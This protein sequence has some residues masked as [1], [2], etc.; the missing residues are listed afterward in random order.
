M[1]VIRLKRFDR[2]KVMAH[3]NSLFLFDDNLE[4]RGRGGQAVIRDLPNAL[5]VPTRRAPRRDESAYFTD[6]DYNKV[7]R[8]IYE[9]FRKAYTH[10]RLGKDV[11]IPLDG[12]GTGLAQLPKR[13]PAIHEVI[14]SEIAFLERIFGT[15]TP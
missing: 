1:P 4:R 13:A 6:S 5:G 14:K 11:V 15:R 8:L 3:P 12:L 10:L 2:E 7:A 9:V